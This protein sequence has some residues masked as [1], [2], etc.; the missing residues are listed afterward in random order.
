MPNIYQILQEYLKQEESEPGS[1]EEG[2]ARLLLLVSRLEYLQN[3][4]IIFCKY[5]QNIYQISQEYLKQEEGEP[6]SREEGGACSEQSQCN[7]IDIN[8]VC[9]WVS[10]RFQKM[11]KNWFLKKIIFIPIKKCKKQDWYQLGL[12]VSHE[13]SFKKFLKDSTFHSYYV[14]VCNNID[15]NL[16]CTRVYTTLSFDIAVKMTNMNIRESVDGTHSCRCRQDMAWNSKT[17]E[18][19]VSLIIFVILVWLVRLVGLESSNWACEACEFVSKH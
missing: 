12:Q 15:I 18:C 2:G 16:L 19:Q 7:S 5:L 17:L 14:G 13:G 4:L 6:G 8:L 11:Q 1:R 9:T 10:E 3:I